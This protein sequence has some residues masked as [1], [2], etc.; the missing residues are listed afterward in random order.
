M[1]SVVCGYAGG[2]VP[3]PSYELVCSD[4]TGHAEVV[5]ITYD[6]AMISY[7]DLLKIFFSIHDPTTP[8]QQ[9]VDYGSQY[10]SV[11]LYDSMEFTPATSENT[12]STHQKQP[13]PNTALS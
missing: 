6:P 7:R 12:A 3:N 2:T 9:G 4:T 5:Q 8:N 11:I 10:R 1:N 13:P